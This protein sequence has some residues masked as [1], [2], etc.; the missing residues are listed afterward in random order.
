MGLVGV[1]QNK[2][3]KLMAK[4][5]DNQ[6]RGRIFAAHFKFLM[7]KNY[8]TLFI[9]TPVLSEAQ[10]K[11]T[12][13]KFAKILSD[14]GGTIVNSE[15]WGLRELRY[16]IANKSTGF[17]A[18]LEFAV[19]T[20]AIKVLETEFRRDERVIRFM[21]TVLDKHAVAYNDKRRSGAFNR[22]PA[23]VAAEA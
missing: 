20:P 10:M 13:A 19:D 23:D 7:K 18:L 16:P 9:L 22:K 21:T 15:E 17:Y 11:E 4:G 3:Q 5:F 2:S 8:E 1:W 14:N 6:A 12:V